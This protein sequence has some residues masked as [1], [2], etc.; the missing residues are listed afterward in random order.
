MG[1]GGV[2]D[3]GE[4]ARSVHRWGGARDRGWSRLEQALGPGRAGEELNSWGRSACCCGQRGLGAPSRAPVRPS[5]SLPPQANIFLRVL[6][7]SY[8]GLGNSG[9]AALGEAL[10]ANNVLEDLRLG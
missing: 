4:P 8:N 1:R 3:G 9:A 2:R 5:P 7:L 10:K 6:D